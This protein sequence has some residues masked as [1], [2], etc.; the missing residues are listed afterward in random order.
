MDQVGQPKASDQ[1]MKVA[2]SLRHIMIFYMICIISEIYV[3][4]YIYVYMYS[5]IFS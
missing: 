2:I 3:H 5:N 1:V 4:V